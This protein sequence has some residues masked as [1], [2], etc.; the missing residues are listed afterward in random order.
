M[1]DGGEL[2]Y[3]LGMQIHRDTPHILFLEQS[4]FASDILTKFGIND[5]IDYKA[6]LPTRTR[7]LYGHTIEGHVR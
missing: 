5:V 6:P 2:K 4:C 1:T 3:I 7:E